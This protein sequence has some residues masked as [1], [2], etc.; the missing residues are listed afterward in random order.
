MWFSWPGNCMVPVLMAVS[1]MV[2]QVPDLIVWLLLLPGTCR[3]NNV[4]EGRFLYLMNVKDDN[5]ILNSHSFIVIVYVPFHLTSS[6]SD[7]VNF[8]K[9]FP[10]SFNIFVN[11]FN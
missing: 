4:F 10:N 9:F 6:S 1:R 3:I 7:F 11:I 5:E 2:S 8:L